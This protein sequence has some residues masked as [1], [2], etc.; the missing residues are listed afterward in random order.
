MRKERPPFQGCGTYDVWSQFDVETSQPYAWFL[1]QHFTLP[2]LH[3]AHPRAT[4]I[5][6]RRKNGGTWA[7]SVLHWHSVTTR[8]FKS[9]GLAMI[10]KDDLP[11]KP[12][13]ITYDTLLKDM[14]ASLNRVLD[15][16]EHQRKRKLLM[17]VYRQHLRKVREW[18]EEY[19][20]RLIEINV[21]DDNSGS[22]LADAFQLSESCWSFDADKLDNDWKDFSFPFNESEL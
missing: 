4:I 16:Q 10:R 6:N 8:I 18:T 22:I 9:F 21:D 19:N 5:L 1:P 12:K 2:L 20:H 13:K 3:E 14:Q 7:N 17:Q 15:E 11:P